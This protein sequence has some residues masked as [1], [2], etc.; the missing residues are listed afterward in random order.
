MVL[1]VTE[2]S[3]MTN[4]KRILRYIKA[5]PDFSGALSNI[6]EPFKINSVSD[7]QSVI[8]GEHPVDDFPHLLVEGD[9]TEIIMLE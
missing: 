3:D 4:H 5:S 8:H 1:H 6:A 7:N 9:D 2:T